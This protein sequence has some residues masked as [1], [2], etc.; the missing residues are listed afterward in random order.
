[1]MST[2]DLMYGL[3]F[4]ELEVLGDYAENNLAIGFILSVSIIVMCTT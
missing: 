2:Y 3:L 1:M 4:I